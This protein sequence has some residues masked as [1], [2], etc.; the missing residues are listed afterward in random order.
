MQNSK[1]TYKQKVMS[2][3]Y[4]YALITFAVSLSGCAGTQRY[5]TVEQIRVKNTGILEAMEAAEDVLSEMH[6]KID[7]ADTKSG[8]IRTRPLPGGQF[9]EFWRC[10]NIGADSFLESNLHTIR[11][12]V[13]LEIIR[14]GEDLIIDCNVKVQR[15][16]LPERDIVSSARV[17]QMFSRSKESLQRLK[18]NPYQER[19]MA[20]IDL[21]NDERLTTEILRRIEERIQR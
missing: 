5:E 11:R 10:D 15:L 4:T 19:N 9:F 2:R 18:L 7:K 16:S 13:E 3:L 14:P 12:T 20:W 6:F 1:R 17:Y 21:G 8:Y